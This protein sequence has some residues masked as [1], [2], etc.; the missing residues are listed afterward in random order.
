MKWA[1]AGIILRARLPQA[2]VAADNADNVSLLLEG[3]REVVGKS[4]EGWEA[5]FY[6]W[7]SWRLPK[8]SAMPPRNI[9]QH[10]CCG[11]AVG[12]ARPVENRGLFFVLGHLLSYF[13]QQPG[14]QLGQNAVHDIGER[15]MI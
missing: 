11:E 5:S 8:I 7:R 4:H 13:G 2:D 14:L 12:K 1:Q 9:D 3:L 10:D 15:V 6:K